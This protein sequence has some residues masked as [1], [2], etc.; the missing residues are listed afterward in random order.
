MALAVTM[1]RRRWRSS[2]C[3]AFAQEASAL[4]SALPSALPRHWL[5]VGEATLEPLE[6]A[7]LTSKGLLLR[8]Q[9]AGHMHE[10]VEELGIKERSFS[11][12]S[13]SSWWL[14]LLY[15]EQWVL[16]KSRRRR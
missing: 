7:E 2:S 13:A 16:V 12:S 4:A 1:C 6:L 15:G 14:Y 11:R 9:H 8:S 5:R 3:A 10:A